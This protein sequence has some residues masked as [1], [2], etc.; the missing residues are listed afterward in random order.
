MHPAPPLRRRNFGLCL[1]RFGHEKQKQR[2]CLGDRRFARGKALR[3]GYGKARALLCEAVG[4]ARLYRRSIVDCRT[5][6]ENRTRSCDARTD[7]ERSEEHTSELQSLMRI[8]YAVFCLKKKKI[9][10]HRNK[11]KKDKT[12]SEHKKTKT[13]PINRHS[14]RNKIKF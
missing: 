10:Q 14:R 1:L 6:D 5:G 13:K 3:L 7:G 2:S 8:S 4:Q 12:T 11:Q 9:K